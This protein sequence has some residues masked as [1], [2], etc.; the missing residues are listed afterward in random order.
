M[1]RYCYNISHAVAEI[2][3]RGNDPPLFIPFSR[4]FPFPPFLSLSPLSPFP[5]VKVGPFKSSY[6]IWGRNTD[7]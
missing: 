3:A 4:H 5:A 6:G 2:F 1:L 7:Q